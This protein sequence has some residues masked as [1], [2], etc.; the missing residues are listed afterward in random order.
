V[1]GPEATF[2]GFSPDLEVRID[3]VFVPDSAPVREYRAVPNQEGAYRSDH[4]PLLAVL[5]PWA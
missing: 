5:E 2:H 1:E 4:L 3:Y